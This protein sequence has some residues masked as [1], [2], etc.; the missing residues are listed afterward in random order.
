MKIFDI[1]NDERVNEGLVKTFRD[2]CIQR[3]PA[4]ELGF[5]G[6]F[7]NKSST[8]ELKAGVHFSEV[9]LSIIERL[10]NTYN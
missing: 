5:I 1:L 6:Q 8:I 3:Y 9:N 2:S 10:S 4:T 7:I